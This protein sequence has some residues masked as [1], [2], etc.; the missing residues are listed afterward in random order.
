MCLSPLLLRDGPPTYLTG[1]Q[2]FSLF[3][4][5]ARVGEK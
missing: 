5:V 2:S 4:Y 1:S 3:D